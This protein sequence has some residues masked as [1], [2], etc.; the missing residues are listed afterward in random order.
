MR[1][2]LL[3]FNW[4]EYQIQM[5]NALAA[6]GHDCTVIFK[7]ARVA[8]SVGAELPRLL[9]PAVRYHLIDDRPRGLRDPRQ[10]AT[11]WGLL[12]I[13]KEAAP[14]ALLLHEATTTYLP[15]CLD[16]AVRAPILLTVHDVA[17][18]PGEDSREPARRDRVRRDLRRRARAVV[19][20]GEALRAAYLEQPGTI[21]RDVTAIPHGCYTVLRHWARPGVPETPR[22]ILFFGRIHEY[23]GLD[24]LLG[25]ARRAAARVPDLRV[26]IAGDGADLDGRLADLKS[27]PRIVLYR[28]YLPNEKVAE[29]FQQASIVALPYL[30]GSQSGVVRVAYVFGKPVV[31]TRVGSIPESVRENETGLV[32]PPRDEAALADAMTALLLDDERRRAMGRAALAL[33]EGEMG[34]GRVAERTEA[35]LARLVPGRGGAT[36]VLSSPARQGTASEREKP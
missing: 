13:L 14:D 9:D 21:C 26:I 27:D 10:W 3:S 28:G 6:R 33:A 30:E 5:A 17:T 4:V 36:A 25:A 22:S 23:K 12:R 2:L 32:V 8:E 31:V 11:V 29:V 1:L 7:R 20:H 35:I 15:F 18:H 34:W 16:R 24:V 19:V